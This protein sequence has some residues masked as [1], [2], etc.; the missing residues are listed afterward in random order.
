MHAQKI[1]A[2]RQ[3]IPGFDCNKRGVFPSEDWSIFNMPR[4]LMPDLNRA[5]PDLLLALDRPVNAR[6]FRWGYH[7]ALQVLGLGL[8]RD[9]GGSHV[10]L[11]AFPD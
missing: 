3:D 10:H 6:A 8:G 2:E 4:I 1:L 7:R 5:D 9:G 11:N